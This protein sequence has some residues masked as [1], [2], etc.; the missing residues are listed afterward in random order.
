MSSLRA[1][2]RAR[3]L[4]QAELAARAGVSRQLVGAV[5]AGRHLP[6]VD[7]GLALADALGVDP[8]ELF[9]RPPD[10]VGV[11]DGE[12]VPDGT[13][14]RVGRVGDRLVALPASLGARG[15][16]PADGIV[17]AGALDARP[18]TPGFVVAGCEPGLEALEGTLREA[19]MAALAAMCSTASALEALAAGRVHAAVVHGTEPAARLTGHDVVRVEVARWRVGLA[20]PPGT[21][22]ADALT[23]RCRVIQ[24]EAGAGVQEA[25]TA[26]A[27][28]D[29][30]P[31]PRVGTHVEAA[32]LA[33]ALGLPAVTI[34]PAALAVDVGFHPLAL[35]IA[36]L[37][38]DRVHLD[39]PAVVAGLD[40]LGS[41]AFRRR[42][43]AV[44]GYDLADAGVVR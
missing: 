39:D 9:G 25:F 22:A 15:W 1:L 34:E 27:E 13:P 14:V 42:L 16:A 29:A 2:R 12:P 23:G 24:R 33:V 20:L 18:L 32:R 21:S 43:E 37:W 8:H 40:V 44:G 11:L 19:G 5:E 36:E 38:I 31:G 30:V 3:G 6:R 26:A 28:V 4:T 41:A 10:V 17:V 35:H 7:A